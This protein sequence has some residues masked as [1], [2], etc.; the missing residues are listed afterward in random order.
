MCCGADLR[1]KAP[2]TVWPES[3]MLIGPPKPRL[4]SIAEVTP[5]RA[6]MP[7]WKGR[8]FSVSSLSQAIRPE[9]WQPARPNALVTWLSSRPK[10]K[11]RRC[12][13]AEAAAYG[14]G[15][16]AEIVL[17]DRSQRH[18]Q[19]VFDLT[20]QDDRGH[21]IGTR[22]AGLFRYRQRGRRHDGDRMQHA[23]GMMRFDVAGVAHRAVGEGGVDHAGLEAVADD[24][25]PRPCRR[26][27][28]RS[29]RSAGRSRFSD[30]PRPAAHRCRRGSSA[31]RGRAPARARRWP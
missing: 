1:L 25:A 15:M 17:L 28:R 5:L 22:R 21:E 12:C 30:S 11:C 24:A 29:P 20:A 18:R 31:G 16:E 7:I 9:A 27:R 13:G 8:E 19:A 2:N 3:K 23:L 4:A 10:Q 14:G 26:D 6:A